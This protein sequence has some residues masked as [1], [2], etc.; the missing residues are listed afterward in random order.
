MNI[1]QKYVDM[2]NNGWNNDKDNDEYDEEIDI[3]GARRRKKS[4]SKNK[5]GCCGSGMEGGVTYQKM[6]QAIAKHNRKSGT[7]K[8]NAGVGSTKAV[9]LRAYNKI[10]GKRGGVSLVRPKDLEDAIVLIS[11]KEPFSKDLLSMSKIDGWD[12]PS[13]V[14]FVEDALSGRIKTVNQLKR[15]VDEN[16]PLDVRLEEPFEDDVVGKSIKCNYNKETMDLCRRISRMENAYRRKYGA[17][18]LENKDSAF[19]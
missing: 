11:K 10:K 6:I 17:N 9:V 5:G 13:I 19:M 12:A 3:E 2:L 1:K 14:S 15:Y 7:K 18:S 8:I 16:T 4:V